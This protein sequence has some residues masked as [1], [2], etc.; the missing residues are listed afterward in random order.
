MIALELP[1]LVFACLF[2]T[3]AGILFV[4]ISYELVERHRARRALR[5]RLRCPLCGMEFADASSEPLPRCP[6]CRSL[7]ERRKPQ[8]F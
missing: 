3:I 2:V 1:W 6:R 4:W 8:F 7:T 5:H